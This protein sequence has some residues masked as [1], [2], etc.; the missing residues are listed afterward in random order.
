MHYVAGQFCIMDNHV[1]WLLTP[2]SAQGLARL[3]R[4]VHTWWAMT[5]NRRHG[6]SGPLMQGRFHSSPLSEDHYWTALR[7][8]E[9]NPRR[10]NLVRHAE[11]FTF[12]SARARLAGEDDPFVVLAEIGTRKQFSCDEWRSFLEHPDPDRDQALRKALPSSLPCGS[13]DWIRDLEQQFQ[14]KL[15][16][17]PPGRL[18]AAQHSPGA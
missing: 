7:Y 2:T 12:S 13:S 15:T 5:F 9:L 14:R 16:C 6:R 4:R 18:C 3:F 8:V 17:S 11:D 10:A 1:H